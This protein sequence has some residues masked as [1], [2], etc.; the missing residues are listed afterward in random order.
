MLLTRTKIR[1]YLKKDESVLVYKDT[2]GNYETQRNHRKPIYKEHL[3]L[4]QRIPPGLTPSEFIIFTDAEKEPKEG[5]M[6]LL[7]ANRVNRY[8][9]GIV[10]DEIRLVD[11]GTHAWAWVDKLKV[12]TRR[13]EALED[14]D[15]WA[16]LLINGLA[17]VFFIA[18]ILVPTLWAFLLPIFQKG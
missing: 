8:F 5:Y 6:R 10:G 3:S 11:G 14:F 13:R 18:F 12:G 17:I 15:L 2:Q 9:P 4:E 16:P 7:V 1:E